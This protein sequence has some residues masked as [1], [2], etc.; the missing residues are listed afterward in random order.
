MSTDLEDHYGGDAID[1]IFALARQLDP[2]AWA[3]RDRLWQERAVNPDRMDQVPRN[4]TERRMSDR[5]M[6]SIA[7]ATDRDLD[8]EGILSLKE[9]NNRGALN[10]DG[11]SASLPTAGPPIGDL[12]F[13]WCLIA[14]G[15]LP[16]QRCSAG[17]RRV[18]IETGTGGAPTRAGGVAAGA[19][20]PAD[21]CAGAVRFNARW[22]PLTP[23]RVVVAYQLS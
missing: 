5:R 9:S 23:S 7:V 3:A 8:P 18:R 19:A 15:D 20:I 16:P 12:G 21:L 13:G 1:E 10:R 6:R 11:E 2:E 14:L 4:A 22:R 17:L